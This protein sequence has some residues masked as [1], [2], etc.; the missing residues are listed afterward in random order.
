MN[1]TVNL[2]E[3]S[4]TGPAGAVGPSRG[5]AQPRRPWDGSSGEKDGEGGRE[6]R[7]PCWA[8]GGIRIPAPLPEAG[9]S[10]ASL[11][12]VGQVSEPVPA[13]PLPPRD[14]SAQ[15]TCLWPPPCGLRLPVP[16]GPL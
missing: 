14:A 4:A 5:A 6:T 8:L 15:A 2:P 3:A 12:A 9:C 1:V 11:W 13:S 7:L 16:S 10:V